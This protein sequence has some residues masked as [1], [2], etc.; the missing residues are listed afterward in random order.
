MAFHTDARIKRPT[1]PYVALGESNQNLPINTP[2]AATRPTQNG[3]R[4]RRIDARKPNA[5][6][7]SDRTTNVSGSKYLVETKNPR[8]S[9]DNKAA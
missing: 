4:P 8:P 5:A 3:P 6:T 1:L 9:D 7:A 2:L